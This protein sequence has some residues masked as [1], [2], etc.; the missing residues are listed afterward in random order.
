MAKHLAALSGQRGNSA[1]RR[2]IEILELVR[3]QTLR[4]A[5]VAAAGN[6]SIAPRTRPIN[7]QRPRSVLQWHDLRRRTE[8]PRD[9]RFTRATAGDGTDGLINRLCDV[10]NEVAKVRDPATHRLD[11]R[12]GQFIISLM[13]FLLKM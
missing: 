3:D 7:A 11:F 4:L 13:T 9:N 1:N 10:I 8:R 12:I 5:S 2:K 6:V